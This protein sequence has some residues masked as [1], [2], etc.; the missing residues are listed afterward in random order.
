LLHVVHVGAA[1]SI[2]DW[3]ASSYVHTHDASLTSSLH[4]SPFGPGALK[5][6]TQIVFSV[7]SRQASSD[8]SHGFGGAAG[9]GSEQT[10]SQLSGQLVSAGFAR[11]TFQHELHGSSG[12]GGAGHAART[13]SQSVL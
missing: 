3:H 4:G 1:A 7:V 11:Q 9:V 10:S 13:K 2:A 12:G 8:V 6:S 5:V